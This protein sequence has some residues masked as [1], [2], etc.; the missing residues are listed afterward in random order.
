ML[1]QEETAMA[2]TRLL[3]IHDVEHAPPEGDWELID[4]E[5]VEMAPAADESSSTGATILIHLGSYVLSQ[6]LGRMYGADGGFVLFPERATIRVPDVAFVRTER[7][8]QGEA[9]R[10]FP[11]LAPD[12][13]VEV[14]SPSGSAS[15][16]VAKLEMY[17]EAG[18]PLIW[19]VDPAKQTITVKASEMPA[20]ILKPGDTLDGG[21]I[22]PGFSIPVAKVFA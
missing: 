5:L 6:G 16:A 11:R 15:D 8:P 18:V 14:L 3:T 13:I 10:R 1:A 9:R 2:T 22:I 12:L 21:E 19:L 4:G 17:Q 7:V 20:K